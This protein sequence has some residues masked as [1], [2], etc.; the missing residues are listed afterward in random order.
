MAGWRIGTLSRGIRG[1]C[2][3]R[4]ELL[5][6]Y[7]AAQGCVGQEEGG[8]HQ[9]GISGAPGALYDKLDA[10]EACVNRSPDGFSVMSVGKD[11]SI[12]ID[13]SKRRAIYAT[14]QRHGGID[15]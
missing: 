6:E 10:C 12:R 4:P 14:V 7:A 11:D 8:G 1:Q 13:K 15:Y 2:A 3:V 9:A 5:H